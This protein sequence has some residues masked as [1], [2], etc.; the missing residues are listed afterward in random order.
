LR[1][2][3]GSFAEKVAGIIEFVS[4]TSKRHI[5]VS[6]AGCVAG[7]FLPQPSPEQARDCSTFVVVGLESGM[8]RLF[9]NEW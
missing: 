6:I 7:Y 2:P 1:Y 5:K 9:F 8:A 3:L 4:Q